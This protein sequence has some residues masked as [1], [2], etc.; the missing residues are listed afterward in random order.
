MVLEETKLQNGWWNLVGGT[1]SRDNKLI[2]ER[3]SPFI[4][5]LI[6]ELLGLFLE[7]LAQLVKD[8]TKGSI[9][10]HPWPTSPKVQYITNLWS[11][12]PILQ[13]ISPFLKCHKSISK[14][15]MKPNKLPILKPIYKLIPK[16]TIKP[17]SSSTI[18][19]STQKTSLIDQ[20]W[21]SD[22]FVELKDFI[23]N[24]HKPKFK[25]K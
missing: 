11:N 6:Q 8:H 25:C 20:E 1:W 13:S 9:L 7:A 5:F 18:G 19:R 12:L 21:T 15:T 10:Y 17:N 24:V 3:A 22:S 16:L 23:N 4:L 14:P 2:R